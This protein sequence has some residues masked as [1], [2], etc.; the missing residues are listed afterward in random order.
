MSKFHKAGNSSE[1]FSISQDLNITWRSLR[2]SNRIMLFD[3]ENFDNRHYR[4]ERDLLYALSI[5]AFS[6]SG[7]R[8]YT[9][10]QAK[11]TPNVSIWFKLAKTIYLD[12]SVIGSGREQIDAPHK[13]DIRCQVR[14]S[15]K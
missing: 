2:L 15:F 1:G 11:V 13:T 8:Y 5:P 6:G 4:Y 9:M 7:Y 3:T 14:Y 10:F 12:R